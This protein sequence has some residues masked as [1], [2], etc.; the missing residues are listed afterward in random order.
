MFINQYHSFKYHGK[1]KLGIVSKSLLT[2]TK[3]PK[4]IK[5]KPEKELQAKLF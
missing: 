3:E 4:P 1:T 2:L 5:F